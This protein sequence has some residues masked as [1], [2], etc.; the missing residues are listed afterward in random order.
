MGQAFWHAATTCQILNYVFSHISPGLAVSLLS[1]LTR[2]YCVPLVTSHQVL[3]CP[4][5]HF[6]P[7]LTVSLLS[8]LT[9]SYCVPLV[10]SHQ[11]LLCPYCH[12]SP[13]LT[14]SLLSLLAR[15]CRWELEV[16]SHLRIFF[17]VLSFR[18]LIEMSFESHSKYIWSKMQC[19]VDSFN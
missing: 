6:S 18:Y 16:F 9:R 17:I 1:H 4:F 3:L 8:L 10:T 19:R 7:G 11:V 2:S 13:G 12:F 15:Y 5:C 14:V